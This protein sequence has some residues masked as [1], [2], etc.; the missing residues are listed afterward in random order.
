MHRIQVRRDSLGGVGKFFGPGGG[1]CRGVDGLGLDFLF[2]CDRFVMLLAIGSVMVP[3]IWLW[4]WCVIPEPGP[5]VVCPGQR[6]AEIGEGI[7]TGEAFGFRRFDVDQGRTEAGGEAFPF[8]LTG[9]T[10]DDP[11][12]RP[13]AVTGADLVEQAVAQ[14]EGH[15]AQLVGPV[16]QR[17][18]G[19]SAVQ[20]I[21]IDD[22]ITALHVFADVCRLPGKRRAVD[23][24][25]LPPAVNVSALSMI[26]GMARR[27]QYFNVGGIQRD[28]GIGEGF[29]GQVDFVVTNELRCVD[30]GFPAALAGAE[31]FCDQARAKIPP[32]A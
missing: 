18:Q 30:E 9:Q 7:Q 4:L 29:I 12:G 6:G 31:P 13:C 1:G 15:A 8:D 20:L 24:E 10:G 11:G 19:N 16:I 14:G 5:G 23:D 22:E 17:T 21:I 32:W 28:G 2:C 27:T 25:D 3:A 26:E